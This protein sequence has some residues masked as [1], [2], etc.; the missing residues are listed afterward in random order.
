MLFK[1]SETTLP[2]EHHAS[3][4]ALAERMKQD[5]ALRIS[6]V[7]HATGSG[8]QA[9]NARRM[10]LARALAVRAYL[11]DQGIDNLRINVQAEG[12]KNAGDQPDRVDLFLLVPVK[13]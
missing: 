4:T 6:V 3:L 12:G 8:D 2:S 7:A 5:P 9:S 10:S 1:P 11:I 13:G